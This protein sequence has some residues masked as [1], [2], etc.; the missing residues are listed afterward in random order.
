M[1]Y[2]PELTQKYSCVLRRV[3]WSMGEPMTRT[4]EWVFED[5]VNR[6]DS[7]VICKTCKDPSQCVTCPF[8]MEGKPS[9]R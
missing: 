7:Q 3:A 6:L 5:L 1:A 8:S 9:G 2:T 4:M